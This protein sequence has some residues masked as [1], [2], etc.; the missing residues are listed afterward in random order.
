MDPDLRGCTTDLIYK[1]IIQIYNI[2]DTTK[3][4]EITDYFTTITTN[5]KRL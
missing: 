5:F 3:M 2:L 4:F 1:Y